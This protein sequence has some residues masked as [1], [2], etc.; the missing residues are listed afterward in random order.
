[1]CLSNFFSLHSLQYN[2]CMLYLALRVFSVVSR[3]LLYSMMIC[4]QNNETDVRTFLHVNK[5][6]SQLSSYIAKAGFHVLVTTNDICGILL[7]ETCIVKE[8]GLIVFDE[9]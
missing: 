9:L 6:S 5:S 1:M 4:L 2:K 7:K 8:C 3:Y